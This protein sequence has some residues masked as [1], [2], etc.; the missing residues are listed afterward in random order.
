LEW[1]EKEVLGQMLSSR[2]AALMFRDELGFLPDPIKH[3][4]AMTILDY[5]RNHAEIILADF[6][7][8][9]QDN[10]L[11][12]LVTELSNNEIYYKE[13]NGHALRDALMQCK[14]S[15]LNEKIDLLK[16]ASRRTEDLTQRSAYAKQVE[17]LRNEKLRLKE[18]KK[19]D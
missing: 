6:I 2:N 15:I 11:V 8:T 19:E 5:Y 12:S 7:N 10:A 3:A 1:A 18:T 13:Y 4:T 14:A 17:E 9:L 16:E